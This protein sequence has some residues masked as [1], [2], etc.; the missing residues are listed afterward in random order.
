MVDVFSGIESVYTVSVVADYCS[1][2]LQQ[3]PFSSAYLKEAITQLVT[4]CNKLNIS[5]LSK[6]TH[7][8]YTENMNILKG[9]TIRETTPFR[10]L[11]IYYKTLRILVVL[12]LILYNLYA[13]P[14]GCMWL[15]R[16]A[17]C[18]RYLENG[19][20]TLAIDLGESIVAHSV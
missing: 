9:A 13:R 11:V 5:A 19:N 17:D 12:L 8:V 1:N 15:D 20:Y 16:Y 18:L 3:I 4:Y 10:E 6:N 7:K 14:V 2:A